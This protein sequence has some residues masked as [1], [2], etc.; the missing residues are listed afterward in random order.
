[1]NRFRLLGSLAPFTDKCRAGND[2]KHKRSEKLEGSTLEKPYLISDG[3][4]PCRSVS[5]VRN[6]RGSRCVAYA[7]ANEAVTKLSSGN[8]RWMRTL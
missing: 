4:V 2:P 7:S 5:H 8:G 1:L 3:L 6:R